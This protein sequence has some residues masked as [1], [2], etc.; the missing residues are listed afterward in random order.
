LPTTG[1]KTVLVRRKPVPLQKASIAVPPR[2]FAMIGSATDNEVASKA[3][4]RVRTE[5]D[6][7]ASLNRHPGLNT[8][9]L[10]GFEDVCEELEL[11]GAC[12]IISFS[13]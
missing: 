2:A 8:G 4:I 10:A 3:T 5:S 7:K 11:T 9:A 1:W 12:P 13:I 6:A